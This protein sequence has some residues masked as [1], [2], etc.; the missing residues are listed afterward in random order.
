MAVLRRVAAQEV[1]DS[2]SRIRRGIW[3]EEEGDGTREF[4]AQERTHIDFKGVLAHVDPGTRQ[5]PSRERSG[6]IV[7][8]P[9]RNA[10][11]FASSAVPSTPP[12]QSGSSHEAAQRHLHVLVAVSHHYVRNVEACRPQQLPVRT[13][14]GSLDASDDNP[15]SVEVEPESFCDAAHDVD[16]GDS[17]DQDDCFRE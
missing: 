2:L 14:V 6:S 11:T 3:A 12:D 16:V 10:T 5:L 4:S 15:P 1:V 17:L 7:V 9:P 13:E 8:S